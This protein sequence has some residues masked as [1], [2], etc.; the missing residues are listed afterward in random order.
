VSV[1]A[2]IFGKVHIVVSTS[3]HPNYKT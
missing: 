2:L 1:N 3:E